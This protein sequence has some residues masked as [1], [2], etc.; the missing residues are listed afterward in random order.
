MQHCSINFYK[1][2]YALVG[3]LVKGAYLF[4]KIRYLS[5]NLSY[6]LSWHRYCSIYKCKCLNKGRDK[7]ES[8]R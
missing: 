8:D 1:K 4:F 3:I 7:G 2:R 5:L 6:A